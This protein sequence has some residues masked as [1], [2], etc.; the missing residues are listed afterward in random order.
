MFSTVA[1]GQDATT[2]TPIDTTTEP[3][4]TTSTP[5]PT[6]TIPPTTTPTPPPVCNPGNFYGT[7]F[8]QGCDDLFLADAN[9]NIIY[10]LGASGGV[11]G[12]LLNV[13]GS[14][15][16]GSANGVGTAASFYWPAGI[17]MSPDGSFALMGDQHNCLLRKIW[18]QNRT[19]ITAV[20]N[21]C[22]AS[23]GVGTS[24]NIGI[25]SGVSYS[26]NGAVYYLLDGYNT[27]L[28]TYNDN[29]RAVSIFASL[30]G[31]PQG[32][33][34]DISR[35]VYY[36]TDRS[37]VVKSMSMSTKTI[38]SLVTLG[39][40]TNY[41]YSGFGLSPD[42][43]TLAI[44]GF[45]S[46]QVALV[47]LASLTVTN[48]GSGTAGSADGSRTTATFQL[49]GNNSAC[50][51]SN[52]G[53]Y[54]YCAQQN[55]H[56]RAINTG[57]LAVTTILSTG[58]TAA[59]LA[60]AP[61]PCATTS[62]TYACGACPS[63]QYSPAGVCAGCPVGAYCINNVKATCPSHSVSPVNASSCTCN[64]GYAMNGGVCIVCPAGSFCVNG[65]ST[66]CASGKISSAGVSACTTC[67]ANAYCPNSTASVSCPGN[68]TSP[69]GSVS[70]SQCTCLPGF[71]LYQGACVQCPSNSYC[72]D[73]LTMNSCTSNST[74]PA[75]SVNASQCL[76]IA[77]LQS[78][79]GVCSPC[80][81]NAYCM[82]DGVATVCNN[83]S[84]FLQGFGLGC[85][86]LLFLSAAKLYSIGVSNGVAGVP[87]TINT[88][89]STLNI[90]VPPDGSYALLS[91]NCMLYKVNL[92][93]YAKTVIAGSLGSC[94][95]TD[96]VGT[97]A[98]FGSS[99][100][101]AIT[102]IPGSN[103]KF[104]I[105]DG[106]AVRTFDMATLQVHTL[107]SM[108]FSSVAIAVAPDGVTAWVSQAGGVITVNLNTGA[109]S[110]IKYF[111]GTYGTSNQIAISSDGKYLAANIQSLNTISVLN[112]ATGNFATY[113]S[114]FSGDTD[115]TGGSVSMGPFAAGQGVIF[116]GDNSLLYF[117]QGDGYFRY[118][119]RSTGYVK[120]ILTYS[121]IQALGLPGAGLLS[122]L[123]GSCT[124]QSQYQFCNS[125]PSSQNFPYGKCYNC[126]ANNYCINGV[127]Y[128]CP[129]NSVSPAGSTSIGNCSCVTG[130]FLIAGQ[131]QQCPATYTY[132]NGGCACALGYYNVSGVCTPCVQGYYC[133]VNSQ[134][135]TICP[136]GT[137]SA[138]GSSAC[139]TCANPCTNTSIALATC[140]LTTCPAATPVKLGNTSWYGLGR[141]EAST[142]GGLVV[143]PSVW[144]VQGESAIGLMLNS[145]ADRPTS[146]VQS[147]FTVVSGHVYALRFKAV[148]TGLQC[149]AG[150][151][152]TW[153]EPSTTLFT[154]TNVSQSWMDAATSYFTA[155]STSMTLRFTAT[156]PNSALSATVWL[157]HIYLAD[158][159]Q[160]TYSALGS[161]QL[162]SGLAVPHRFSA[163]Y[164]EQY[165]RVVLSIA[166]GAY[167]QHSATV[168][169]VPQ[170][171]QLSVW[172]KGTIAAQYSLNGGTSWASMTAKASID[173]AI[174]PSWSQLVWT[175]SSNLTTT[176][177][178]RLTASSGAALISDPQLIINQT[179][180]NLP[181]VTCIANYW[182]GAAV[183]NLCPLNTLS[184]S[185]AASMGECYCRPGYYGTPF[186]SC[187]I[188]P[189]NYYCAGGTD[190]VVCPNGTY[191]T[192]GSSACMPCP[193]GEYCALGHVGTCPAHSYSGVGAADIT[194]CACVAGYFGIAPNCAQCDVGFYCT[195]G[196]TETA[197]TADAATPPG[198][199]NSAQCTCVSGYYGIHD[200]ACTVCPEVSW[201]FTGLQNACPSNTYSYPY[202]FTTTNCTCQLGYTGPDGGPCSACIAGTYKDHLG[203]DACTQCPSG[204]ISLSTAA[205]SSAT[206]TG[207]GVGTYSGG[208]GSVTCQICNSGTYTS[209][210]SQTV[211][212][213]CAAGTWS[214]NT[215][216]V[217]TTCVAGTWSA[218]GS[219]VCS[220]CAAG[221]WSADSASACTTCTP[222]TWAVADAST[223]TSC[224]AGYYASGSAASTCVTCGAGSFSADVASVCTAC[225][226]GA[227]S[228]STAST[229]TSCTPGLYAS[230]SSASTC[231]NCASGSFSGQNTAS[232]CALCS[233]GSWSHTTASVC[234]SC[235]A[236][237]F[238]N[239][240]GVVDCS[241]CT[242][243]SYSHTAASI[244]T[245][246]TPGS[247]SPR[248]APDCTL[249]VAGTFSTAVSAATVATCQQCAPGYYSVAAGLTVC[250]PCDPGTYS[251]TPALVSQSQCATCPMGGICSG[252]ASLAYCVSGTVGYGTGFSLQSQCSACTSGYYC[253][254]GA[255][256]TTCPLGSYSL[257]TNV[258][259][260]ALCPKCPT[261]NYCTNTTTEIVCPVNT[262]S[263]AGSSDLA[264]CVCN[265]GYR[266]ELVQV[267]HAEI[268]LPINASQFAELQA[269]YIAAVAAAAGVDPSQVIIVSI[270]DAPTGG[271]RRSLDGGLAPDQAIEIHAS[272]Y[273]SM[274][275]G[276]PH[277][278][279][280]T[281]DL[282][283]GS[284]GLPIPLRSIRVSLHREVVRATRVDSVKQPDI[285]S[286]V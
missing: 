253:P 8:L 13:A 272:I 213:T 14:G 204:T 125:C 222:G 46:N 218:D 25:I 120:T 245:A 82:G 189:V 182:C 22:G 87:T 276:S 156:M 249:C 195:G 238:A 264:S 104:A 171:Y 273:N 185:G 100:Y 170:P 1:C 147:V 137:M 215:A 207:C 149:A 180:A 75:G 59:M 173:A 9:N 51:Y 124:T 61:S 248:T 108:P 283:L 96:G 93:N 234:T 181:C 151:T 230:G 163:A 198:A 54:I 7:G 27:L 183:A 113:G 274:H 36:F 15:S 3:P 101:F 33:C 52:D 128:A 256:I 196:A 10:S 118:I 179:M 121:A 34:L 271:A 262:N 133:T 138:S 260:A 48:V 89:Y 129:S 56:I 144:D 143:P 224:T 64:T 250:Q 199:T 247:W 150:L 153:V 65:T 50:V 209:A 246:C 145:T 166:S 231:V 98:R 105:V 279:L 67:A 47:D 123:Q 70:V 186:T 164:V 227:W 31:T 220:T 161:L 268:T 208:G 252:G 148:C 267:V 255:V 239:R 136:A 265:P 135:P 236:G 45:A 80:P 38:T 266:C 37:N 194:Q 158:L 152:A 270:T 94:G 233:P 76:C 278:A 219:S 201:C 142:V 159:G 6:T 257:A 203:T 99:N 160:W 202:S 77:G 217:C 55:G 155:T 205:T 107:T 184:P 244:C 254:G 92:T 192:A 69:A 178:V 12:S 28:W 63:S 237:T 269:A 280:R 122:L 275:T 210:I 58:G 42:N 127:T 259:S 72:P 26:G 263:Q 130:Y 119:N 134:T 190:A 79:Q 43:S 74:S 172:A 197:C 40:S 35:G 139:T 284:L 286:K 132:Y 103:T 146:L 41:Q 91:G 165:P 281:L 221:S 282:E 162:Q 60:M 17:G 19:V 131:C 228:L 2:T 211:C 126:K 102:Y 112:I 5:V 39:T 223:C 11:G 117:T 32:G 86:R 216:S 57:T 78:V 21:G 90:G 157:S 168:F 175:A 200:S 229:C 4:P 285:A 140:G 18:V 251:T 111:P 68:S 169:P 44:P 226:P 193:A 62:D 261:N 109:Q 225:S 258:P 81:A 95:S 240:S 212:A 73:Q 20:G 177:L 23:A 188:C 29:T 83:G 116:S 114:G 206:C 187:A 110:A 16:T 84:A 71:L 115:G 49:F 174:Q 191:S 214:S 232:V 53:M 85:D 30:S 167:I 154:T 97:N 88:V 243:G 24:A 235:V 141:I 241:N 106:S 242:A 66:A 277:R 176:M